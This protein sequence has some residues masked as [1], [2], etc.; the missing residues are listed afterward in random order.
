MLGFICLAWLYFRKMKIRWS[1]G[2]CG[3]R[4]KDKTAM[5]PALANTRRWQRYQVDLPVR[6]I[7]RN[8]I[9]NLDVPGRGTELSRC[10]MALYA[11]LPLEEDDQ[12]EI[13]FLSP[14]K[15]RIAGVIRNRTGYWF[16]LEFLALLPT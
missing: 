5:S 6:V 13:Q 2:R 15:L 14:S 16:G 1:E 8:R 12:V 11:G 7:F 3:A 4:P 10:G 9:L